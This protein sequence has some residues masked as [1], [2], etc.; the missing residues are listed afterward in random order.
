M[1]IKNIFKKL[2]IVYILSFM[3]IG[4]SGCG[5]MSAPE[6]YKGSG[7]PHQYPKPVD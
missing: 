1:K 4:M 5:K 7:Y 3:M 2:L 6:P